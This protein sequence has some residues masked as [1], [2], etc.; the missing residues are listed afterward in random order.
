M[1]FKSVLHEVLTC[2]DI[3]TIRLLQVHT[4]LATSLHWSILFWFKN[5][6]I[7]FLI[8]TVRFVF[9]MNVRVITHMILQ[10]NLQIVLP[11]L[12][13][14]AFKDIEHSPLDFCALLLWS[15]VWYCHGA[16]QNYQES[17]FMRVQEFYFLGSH[18]FSKTWEE[19]S[20]FPL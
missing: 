19:A 6:P 9:M 14:L 16:L 20:H 15:L 17:A 7:P 1:V 11:S 18:S 3:L 4:I 2:I 10:Q 8:I 12:L 5:N 13:T